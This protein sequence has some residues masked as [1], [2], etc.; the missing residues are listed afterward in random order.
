MSANA[1]QTFHWVDYV[2]FG[3]F[4]LTCVIIGLVQ[5]IKDRMGIKQ[6]KKDEHRTTGGRHISAIPAV[7]SV[8]AGA[9]SSSGLLGIPAD[10]YYV[11]GSYGFWAIC[12]GCG[13]VLSMFVLARRFYNLGIVNVFQVL[14]LYKYV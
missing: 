8:V 2:I 4:L 14:K 7:L 10:V 11:N 13:L 6:H 1:K 3:V 12:V 5:G 9:I